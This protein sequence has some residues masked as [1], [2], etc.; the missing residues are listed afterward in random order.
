MSLLVTIILILVI[1]NVLGGAWP[2]YRTG[3]YYGPSWGA[4]LVI[5]VV[6]YLLGYR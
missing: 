5:I 1:L 6:L 4:I 2:A 3:A